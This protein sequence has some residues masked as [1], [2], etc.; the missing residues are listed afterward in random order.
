MFEPIS[1]NVSTSFESVSNNSEYSK[2]LYPF[3]NNNWVK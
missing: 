3:Q 1:K 2:F